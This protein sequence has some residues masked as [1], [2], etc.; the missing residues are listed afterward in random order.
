MGNPGTVG[1][2]AVWRSGVLTVGAH[3]SSE[4]VFAYLTGFSRE[5]WSRG[6]AKQTKM[7]SIYR[8]E[9]KNKWTKQKK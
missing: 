1:V 8:A 7:L 5:A 3:Q 6:I 9:T 2:L 4:S